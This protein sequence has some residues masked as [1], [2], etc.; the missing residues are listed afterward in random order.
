MKL[1]LRTCMCACGME[2]KIPTKADVGTIGEYKPTMFG[3]GTHQK[4]LKVSSYSTK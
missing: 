3:F 2:D 4:G 1:A